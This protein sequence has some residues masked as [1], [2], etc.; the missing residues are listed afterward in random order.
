[1]KNANR[2]LALRLTLMSLGAFAFGFALVPL[3]DVM[4][5]LTGYGNSKTLA[6]AATLAQQGA[7]TQ[8]D[9]TRLVTVEFLAQLPSVGSWE[10]RPQVRSMQVHPGKLYQTNFVAHNLTGRDT[11]AQAVPSVAPSQ[12]TT[13]FHKTECFCFTPQS[14]AIGEQRDM[15]VRF[16][17]DPALP[18]YVDRITLAY[19]FYD[20]PGKI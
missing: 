5:T 9:V 4:C 12:A 8:A 20:S 1:M 6:R 7:A 11:V 10:F 14:F 18:A 3:Y 16:I 13:F 15:P 2:S 19:T 17:V